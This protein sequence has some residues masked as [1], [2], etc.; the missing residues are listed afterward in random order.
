MSDPRI[1]LSGMLDG[2]F[3]RAQRVLTDV[4]EEDAR[5]RPQGLSPVVWQAGHITLTDARSVVR[6]GVPLE[7]PAS[8]PG[9]FD[10]GTGGD[11]GYPPLATIVAFLTDVNSE[12]RRLALEADL[13]KQVEGSRSYA[14]VGEALAF[15]LYHRGYHVGKIAT[16]RAL[17]GKPR[18]FG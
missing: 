6:S 11:A 8:Y 12:M 17:L 2:T 18:V 1:L 3:A 7:I 10:T 16:L 5:V 13:N 9:L 14:S 4:S 15:L